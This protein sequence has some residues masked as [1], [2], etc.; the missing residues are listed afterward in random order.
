MEMEH[1]S[2]CVDSQSNG[3]GRTRL[4]M[5]CSRMN[6][7]KWS[8]TFAV[9]LAAAK[10]NETS[11]NS[12]GPVKTQ[13]YGMQRRDCATGF[14]RTR[15]SHSIY[16]AETTRQQASPTFLARTAHSCIG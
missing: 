11:S 10:L 7:N 14:V 5:N 1:W 16:G 3:L 8:R 9:Q 2:T 6:W 15:G 12:C 13:S 4:C